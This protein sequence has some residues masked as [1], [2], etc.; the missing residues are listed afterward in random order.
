MQ[1]TYAV[2]TKYRTFASKLSAHFIITSHQTIERCGNIENR[3]ILK[4]SFIQMMIQHPWKSSDLI[5]CINVRAA[6][7]TTSCHCWMFQRVAPIWW[8]ESG[9]FIFTHYVRDSL[10]KSCPQIAA[11]EC[12][13]REITAADR[14]CNG[15]RWKFIITNCLFAFFN[16]T[17]SI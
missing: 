2:L 9:C 14:Y 4:M 13:K 6:I 15:M 10:Y 3:L 17:A 5:H 16:D 7:E 1:V 8:R 11:T 12:K